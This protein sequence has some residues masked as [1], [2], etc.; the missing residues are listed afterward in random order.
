MLQVTLGELKAA[1]LHDSSTQDKVA[2]LTRD[3]Q[4]EQQRRSA[5]EDSVR[6]KDDQL[7]AQVAPH[8]TSQCNGHCFQQLAP[9]SSVLH[10]SAVKELATDVTAS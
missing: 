7:L 10:C 5:V 3:L 6:H 1:V 9:G 4:A 2:V 8:S